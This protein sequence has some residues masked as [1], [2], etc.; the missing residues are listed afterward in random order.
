MKASI[1]T[2]ASILIGAQ[3]LPD[4]EDGNWTRSKGRCKRYFAPKDDKS[5]ESK[6][7]KDMT[8]EADDATKC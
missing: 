7:R 8:A 6:D 5:D 2:L 1:L 3:A 4:S